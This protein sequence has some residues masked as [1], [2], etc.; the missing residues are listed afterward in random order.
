MLDDYLIQGA[1]FDTPDLKPCT[2]PRVYSCI[3]KQEP[4]DAFDRLAYCFIG[5]PIENPSLSNEL[6]NRLGLSGSYSFISIPR[7]LVHGVDISLCTGLVKEDDDS[8]IIR[9]LSP[10]SDLALSALEKGIVSRD[11][12]EEMVFTDRKDFPGLV[13]N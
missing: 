3:V 13:C 5:N 1:Y 12:R 9:G 7:S 6:R 10:T 11:R 8:L 2:Q 4:R